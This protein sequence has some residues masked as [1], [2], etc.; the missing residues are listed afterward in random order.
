M[1]KAENLVASEEKNINY[2]GDASND[3]EAAID[4]LFNEQAI[5]KNITERI[6]DQTTHYVE[7]PDMS[8][9]R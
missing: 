8:I 6:E 4:T 1:T 5:L 2:E 3:L 9:S 7:E